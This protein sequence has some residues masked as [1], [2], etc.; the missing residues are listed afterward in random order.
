LPVDLESVVSEL[1]HPDQF[2]SV[3]ARDSSAERDE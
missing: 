3:F 2:E 1:V